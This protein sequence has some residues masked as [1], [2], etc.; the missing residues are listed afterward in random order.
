MRYQERDSPSDESFIF[1]IRAVIE[2]IRAGKEIDKLLL[3]HGLSG[4][5]FQ[6]LRHLVRERNIVHQFVP[7][8][9]LHRITRKNHQ[10]A[11]AF[12]S[13]ISYSDIEKILPGLFEKGKVPLLL[14]L[15]R[16]KDVRN[17]GAICRTALCAGIDAVIIPSRGAA[18]VNADAVKT[19]AGALHQLAVC[20]HDNLK[21]VLEYLKSSGVQIIACT[22]KTDQLY[23]TPDYTQPTLII[24]GSEEDGISGEYLKRADARAKIPLL[25]NIGS[26]NVSAAAGIIVY[27]AVRQ[28]LLK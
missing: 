8:E 19:S 6:E 7:V 17:F 24:M 1:G 9:K 23:Y 10:G 28:R 12:V 14:M 5:L 21:E 11:I 2:A 4:E 3:Q 18:Q 15:D 20:R 22:E 27:E 25:G 26:L 13:Q 16:I